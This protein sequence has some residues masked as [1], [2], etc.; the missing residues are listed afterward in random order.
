[1]IYL[2]YN[3]YKILNKTNGQTQF[4]KVKNVTLFD[5]GYK[6]VCFKIPQ[7]G[8]KGL[9]GF[10][11]A[12]SKK[13]NKIKLKKSSCQKMLLKIHDKTQKATEKTTIEIKKSW[14][15]APVKSNR[16]GRILEAEPGLWHPTPAPHAS[17]SCLPRRRRRHHHEVWT[18]FHPSSIRRRCRFWC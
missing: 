5:G 3:L 8:V 9:L 17:C 1:M 14:K 12:S 6:H 11:L 15:R 4:L 13:I 7:V 2:F 18:R 16:K 10:L